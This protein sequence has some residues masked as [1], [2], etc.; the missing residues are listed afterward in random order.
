MKG[1]ALSMER[2]WVGAYYQ[3]VEFHLH[4][5]AS[6]GHRLWLLIDAL[7]FGLNGGEHHEGSVAGE[8]ISH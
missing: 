4:G 3:S 1:M 2:E 6:D 7:T 5:N 8:D